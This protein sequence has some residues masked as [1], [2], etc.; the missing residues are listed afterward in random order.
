MEKLY[1]VNI[2]SSTQGLRQ[3]L[4]EVVAVGNIAI[5]IDAGYLFKQGSC[6]VFNTELGRHEL[7]LDAQ[8]FVELLGTWICERYPHDDLFRTYW[9]DGARK[10]VPSQDQ[11]NVAALPFVKLRVGRINAAGQQKGVDTLVVRDLMVLSQERSI[12]RAV[13][14]SGDEDLREGIEYAQDRGV[15]VAV[16]GIDASKGR[17]QSVE[18]VREADESLVLPSAVVNATLARKEASAGRRGAEL[19]HLS[20]APPTPADEGRFSMCAAETA[21]DWKRKAT[22]GEIAALLADR[23]RIP[24]E[25]D[26]LILQNA[27]RVTGT[28]VIPEGLRHMMRSAFWAA[29]DKE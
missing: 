8:K 10:G 6:A 21:C 20:V 17:S 29:I 12:H 28:A 7:T 18:L 25:L 19:L 1:S 14:V 27:V 15:R 22:S 13:V 24:K 16:V 4:G 26:A 3:A 9:Y 5:F 23:P 11:L 2:A